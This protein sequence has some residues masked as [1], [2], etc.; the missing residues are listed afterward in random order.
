MGYNDD[1]VFQLPSST[2]KSQNINRNEINSLISKVNND[3]YTYAK[4]ALRNLFLSR[5]NYY[6][7][8]SQEIYK[9]AEIRKISLPNSPSDPEGNLDNVDYQIASPKIRKEYEAFERMT[10]EYEGF[11][12]RVQI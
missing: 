2:L 11:I 3:D 5:V 8:E 1:T 9:N 6:N 10:K 7:I 4:E 12:D